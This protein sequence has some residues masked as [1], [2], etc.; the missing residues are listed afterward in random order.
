MLCILN[1]ALVDLNT[2]FEATCLHATRDVR[3][4]PKGNGE[5]SQAWWSRSPRKPP[6]EP[7]RGRFTTTK[8]INV[9][10]VTAKP[11]RRK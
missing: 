3:S 1:L 7:E 11:E 5:G 4:A 8:H 2:P 10:K 9:P 6:N